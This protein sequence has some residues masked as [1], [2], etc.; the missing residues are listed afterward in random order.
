M[1][2]SIFFQGDIRIGFQSFISCSKKAISKQLSTE[3]ICYIPA[4]DLYFDSNTNMRECLN[5]TEG[6]DSAHK[7]QFLALDFGANSENYGCPL[8]CQRQSYKFFLNTLHR[9]S[10][11]FEIPQNFTEEDVYILSFYYK[12]LLVEKHVE[13]L[14]YDFGGFLAAAGGNMGLC[15][16]LSFLS[17]LFTFTH[18]T[19]SLL[20][21]IQQETILNYDQNR[22]P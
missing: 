2:N 6:K 21:W 14:V 16:G 19:K 5:E 12:T 9:N 18:W 4:F 13:T 3:A 11:L 8:P 1:L 15:L 20:Q 7:L 10:M 17:I 22:L